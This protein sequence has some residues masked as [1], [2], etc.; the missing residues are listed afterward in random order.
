[1]DIIL[2]GK[3]KE[4]ANCKGPWLNTITVKTKKGREYVLDRD[5]TG[6]TIYG[7]RL[8]MVWHNVYIWNGSEPDYNIPDDIR[9]AEIIRYEIED[10]AEDGYDLKITTRRIIT[11]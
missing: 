5:E 10:D 11:H 3:I 4:T 1:M 9:N 2:K 6:Y 7:N 8:E